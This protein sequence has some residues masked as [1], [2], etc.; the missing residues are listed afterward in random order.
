M[1]LSRLQHWL[2]KFS[3]AE[4]LGSMT[5]FTL[6]NSRLTLANP[7]L[8]S[9]LNNSHS[10]QPCKYST[11]QVGSCFRGQGV[12]ILPSCFGC[13]ALP[14][15]RTSEPWKP[16]SSSCRAGCC[17]R[18]QGPPPAWAPPPGFSGRQRQGK[19]VHH[20]SPASPLSPQHRA[21]LDDAH[22]CTSRKGLLRAF[23]LVSV[24][25]WPMYGLQTL[26][27]VVPGPPSLT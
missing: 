19:F 7:L 5:T 4:P 3:N 2:L 27:P 16:R 10:A 13:R 26:F 17:S 8:T 9:K 24:T 6:Q 1:G 23:S 14:G 22:I 12:A 11:S 18:A 15:M 25:F 20:P 21:G